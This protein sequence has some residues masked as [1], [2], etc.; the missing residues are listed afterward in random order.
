MEYAC[1]L[2]IFKLGEISIDGT[3]IQA[4]ASK[5]KAMSWEYANQLE[6][7]FQAEVEALLHKSQTEAGESFRDLDLPQELP[8]R[9]ERLEKSA[10]AQDR[11]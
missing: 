2:G 1:N 8:R 10:S 9:Q 6:V 3:K 5:H 11:D 7:Q 4:N